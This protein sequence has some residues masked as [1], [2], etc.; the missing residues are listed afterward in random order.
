MQRADV[1]RVSTQTIPIVK[2]ATMPA[3]KTTAIRVLLTDSTT[4]AKE[5]ALV[6]VSAVLLTD[7]RVPSA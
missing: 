7:S 2:G 4:A 1:A 3:V 6:S 5:V